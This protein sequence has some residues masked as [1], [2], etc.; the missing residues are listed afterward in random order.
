VTQLDLKPR[1]HVTVTLTKDEMLHGALVGCTRQIDNLYA[2]VSNAHGA[3]HSFDANVLGAL[4]EMAVAKHF[5]VYWNGNLGDF[6]AKD[7]G[8]AQVRTTDTPNG[9]LIVHPPP[10]SLGFSSTGRE[11]RRK[12]DLATDPFILVAFKWETSSF[13]TFWL[14]GWLL[15]GHAQR[16]E[17]WRE[18]GVRSPAY[19]VPPDQLDPIER[20]QLP[21]SA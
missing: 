8:G 19:F 3:R 18:D 20:L 14:R 9:C 4:G 11:T 6:R 7:V 17:F 2:H 16:S 1:A 15:G 5:G 21:W 10:H 13:P 12:G